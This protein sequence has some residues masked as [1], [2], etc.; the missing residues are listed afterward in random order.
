[1]STAGSILTAAAVFFGTMSATWMTLRFLVRRQI[2]DQPNERSSHSVPVPRGLGAGVIPVV[3]IA[4]LFAARGAQFGTEV[5]WICAG[6]MILAIVSWIDDLRDLPIVPRLLAQIF[7]TSAGVYIA[8]VPS[9]WLGALIVVIWM[10]IINQVNFTDG[11]DGNLGVMLVCV[12]AGLFAAT[13]RSELEELG[14]FA[15][16]LAVAAGGFLVWNWHPARG[17]MGDVGSVPLGFMLGWLLLRTFFSEL[18]AVAL[19]LPFFYLVDTVMTYSRRVMRVRA[20][21]R[22]HREYLYQRAASV[23]THAHVVTTILGCN[24]VLIVLAVA[25]S[26]GLRWE[27]IV[28]ALIATAV[29]YAYLARG[30]SSS[31]ERA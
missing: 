23:K 20:F 14:T 27:A 21:W 29:T 17:F 19:I 16:L 25:A 10:G 11:I 6:A 3:V 1:M 31:R 15:L 7:V 8:G 9:I 26:R 24:I 22:P 13:R 4:W 28:A 12:G 18:W 2:L 30:I 5:R